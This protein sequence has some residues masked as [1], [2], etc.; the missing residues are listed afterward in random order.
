MI[1][2]LTLSVF[3]GTVNLSS[4][5]FMGLN[6]S[7]NVAIFVLAVAVKPVTAVGALKIH[8]LPYLNIVK[9]P[10]LR[11]SLSKVYSCIVLKL[12]FS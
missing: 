6:S 9:Y 11:Y 12:L 2:K 8:N 4:T 7:G 5:F 3:D 1:P 10:V